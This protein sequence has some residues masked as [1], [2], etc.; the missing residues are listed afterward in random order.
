MAL[1]I[2][3]QDQWRF[4]QFPFM[5]AVN[6]PLL[7][8]FICNLFPLLC[9]IHPWQ[10]NKL[11]VIYFFVDKPFVRAGIH[12]IDVFL[13]LWFNK[14]LFTSLPTFPPGP[15][16]DLWFLFCFLTFLPERF[17]PLSQVLSVVLSIDISLKC[18]MSVSNRLKQRYMPQKAIDLQS[19]FSAGRS[20]QLSTQVHATCLLGCIYVH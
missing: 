19:A 17:F 18:L 4:L 3:F 7:F 13:L 1:C 8:S 16:A 12:L 11:L 10:T 20:A 15:S 14:S 9:C 6:L 5:N 2:Y